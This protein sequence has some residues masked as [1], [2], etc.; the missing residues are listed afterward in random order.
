VKKKKKGTKGSLVIDK[1]GHY[2]NQKKKNVPAKTAK[3]RWHLSGSPVK[4]T[5]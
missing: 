1:R 2:L 4:K 5:G 3:G